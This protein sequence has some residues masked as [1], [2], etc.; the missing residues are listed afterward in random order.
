MLCLASRYPADTICRDI[1]SENWSV[2]NPVR[3]ANF[4]LK[5]LLSQIDLALH[6]LPM[7]QFVAGAHTNLDVSSS[8]NLVGSTILSG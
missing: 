7:D 8:F 2:D 5:D 3:V 1:G 6:D 4:L